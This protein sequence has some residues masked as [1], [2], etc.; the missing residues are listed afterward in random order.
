MQ[1]RIDGKTVRATIPAGQS[2]SLHLSGVFLPTAGWMLA[3]VA[4]QSKENES[5]A[6]P[7]VLATLDLRGRIVS[8]DAIFAQRD[9]SAHIM[10][11]GSAYLWTVDGLGAGAEAGTGAA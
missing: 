10:E 1:V 11:Q 2:H 9:L 6:A 4:V 7:R 3:E 5:T 8:G